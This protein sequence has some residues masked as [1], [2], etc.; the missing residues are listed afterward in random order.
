M[1]NQQV[2]RLATCLQLLANEAKTHKQRTSRNISKT[3]VMIYGAAT[4]GALFAIAIFFYFFQ[5]TQGIKRS[6]NHLNT[7][8]TQMTDMRSSMDNIAFDV[9]QMGLNVSYI[10]LMNPSV[11]SIARDAVDINTHVAQLKQ[12]TSVIVQESA[13]I[14]GSTSIIDQHF[15]RINYSVTKMSRSINHVAK[16]INRFMP[17]P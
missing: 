10:G 8:E 17:F 15:G 2:E 11:K 16:P 6:V 3:N 14:G 9:D 12:N 13:A 4:I 5:L 7:L 1:N